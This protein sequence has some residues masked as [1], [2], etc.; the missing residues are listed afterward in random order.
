M[1]SRCGQ[2]FWIGGQRK[3]GNSKEMALNKNSQQNS[4]G[5]QTEGPNSKRLKPPAPNEKRNLL[6]RKNYYLRILEI[7]L[8][9]RYIK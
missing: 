5:S 4:G 2:T 7:N 1:K 9:Y 3:H 8:F 6:L